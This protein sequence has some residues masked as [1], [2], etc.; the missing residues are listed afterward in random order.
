MAVTSMANS[1][2]GNFVKY[3]NM[4]GPSE[5]FRMDF[6]AI[7]GGGSGGV[8]VAGGGGAGGYRCSVEGETNGGGEPLESA[9]TTKGV[10][11]LTVGAGAPSPTTSARGD[12]GS[13][14]VL[15]SL[16]IEG[17]GSGAFQSSAVGGT[18]GAGGGGG[19]TGGGA[20][21]TGNQGYNGGTAGASLSSGA[22][23]GGAGAVGGNN[24]ASTG[25][26]GGDG[27]SSSITGSAV[28]RGGGGGGGSNNPGA[29][30]AGGGG[31]GALNAATS[32]VANT[33]G[34][35]G[36]GYNEYSNSGRAG[37]GGS[38]VIILRAPRSLQVT[39]SAGVTQSTVIDGAYFAYNITAAGPTDTMTIS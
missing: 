35:G 39:F 33:G 10:Y 29:G 26:D 6:L 15:G 11:A 37:A 3:N 30:G 13:N 7:A 19:S 1:S 4:T 23:G 25:G 20:G 31:A 24:A 36:A 2:I 21:G 9:I 5:S 22:G 32:G 27:L 8:W 34:G 17:G 18:G 14:S 28:T 38:G 12:K 16:Q